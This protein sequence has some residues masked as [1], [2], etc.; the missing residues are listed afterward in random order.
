MTALGDFSRIMDALFVKLAA[1]TSL[2]GYCETVLT[3][4]F[5]VNFTPLQNII[6]F[7]I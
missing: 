1:T 2:F 3:P 6:T 7:S 4:S 5:H